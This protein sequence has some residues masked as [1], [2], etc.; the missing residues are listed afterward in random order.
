MTPTN[1]TKKMVEAD[2]ESMHVRSR[3]P[4]TTILILINHRSVIR[5]GEQV[6][7]KAVKTQD[8]QIITSKYTLL[9][10][11]PKNLFL[12]FRRVGN[13]YFLMTTI[14]QV[15]RTS[16]SEVINLMINIFYDQTFS[17]LYR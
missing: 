17:D 8:N 7:E 10:F 3:V 13:F 11:L 14:I 5:Q 1:R 4:K 16:N 6:E 15:I 2:V 9:N 12:Q